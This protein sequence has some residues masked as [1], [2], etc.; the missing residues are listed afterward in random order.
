M[1]VTM[2]MGSKSVMLEHENGA[3]VTWTI[4]NTLAIYSGLDAMVFWILTKVHLLSII[5]SFEWAT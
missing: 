2:A 5:E 3:I 1:Q 4:Q